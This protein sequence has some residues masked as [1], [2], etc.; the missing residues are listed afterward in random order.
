MFL[1][2]PNGK[3]KMVSL[4]FR[5]YPAL[6]QDNSL[7]VQPVTALCLWL[8]TDPRFSMSFQLSNYRSL[9]AQAEM[10]V[11]LPRKVTRGAG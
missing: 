5:V 1:F 7:L 10:L 3:E 6:Y 9:N 4:G 2:T 11:T 8:I